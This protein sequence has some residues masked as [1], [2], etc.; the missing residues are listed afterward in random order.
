MS[1]LSIPA[2]FYVTTYVKSEGGVVFYNSLQSLALSFSADGSQELS[3]FH[4]FIARYKMLFTQADE[5]S[6]DREK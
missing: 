2:E 4:L 6:G 5:L 1:I 3:C